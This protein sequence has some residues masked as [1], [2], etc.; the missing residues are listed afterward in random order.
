M[1][2]Q[3]NVQSSDGKTG[4]QAVRSLS[5]Q[6]HRVFEDVKGLGASAV[7][8]AADVA[9]QIRERGAAAYEAGKERA[10]QAY[11]SGKERASQAKGQVET[12]I[13]EN[14]LKSVLIAVG[15]GALLGYSLRRR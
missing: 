2:I 14:P 10:S 9:D 12:V 13:S 8:S 4:R 6:S 15:I 7:A 3:G 11:E 1:D 5:E